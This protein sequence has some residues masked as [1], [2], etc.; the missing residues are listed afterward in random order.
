M[1]NN[2]SPTAPIFVPRSAKSVTFRKVFP[3]QDVVATL[4]D[5]LVSYDVEKVT[6]LT[7]INTNK[8]LY[9]GGSS[10]FSSNR[11]V[12]YKMR[13]SLRKVK[14]KICWIIVLQLHLRMKISIQGNNAIIKISMKERAVEVVR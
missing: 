9:V 14:K 7:L 3:S 13:I 2:L 12:N 4:N 11:F 8:Q 5:H 1:Q 6:S 10:Q